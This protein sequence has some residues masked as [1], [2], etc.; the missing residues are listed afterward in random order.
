[1]IRNGA[2]EPEVD[3]LIRFLVKMGAQVQRADKKTLQI[4][5]VQSLQECEY[6]A[7]GD[8]IEAGTYIMAALACGGEVK[9]SGFRPEYLN[10]VLDILQRMG[11]RLHIGSDYVEVF[12]SELHSVSVQT[13]PYPGLPTDLQAQ[14]MAL[15]LKA[16]GTSVIKETIFENRFMH[17][18]ELQRLGASIV[19]EGNKAKIRGM[20]NL[21]GAP[22]MCSDLRASAALVIAAL[23]S[24]GTT[25]ISRIYHLERG[26]ERLF[27]KLRSLGAQIQKVGR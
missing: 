4:C 13:A 10:D 12:P 6:E 27:E 7:I 19:L 16:Q 14:L 1:M 22:V 17:V 21:R 25:E 8:R 18:P 15:C 5:G 20:Q 11:A 24:S 26:H 2:L 9:V 3:D 23:M